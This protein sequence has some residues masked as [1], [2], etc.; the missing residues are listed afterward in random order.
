MN[1]TRIALFLD[2]AAAELARG[3]LARV[4]VQAE[5]H[6]GPLVA[7]LWFVSKRERGLRLE[8]P[9]SESE[10]AAFLLHQWEN[11]TGVLQ[12]AIRCPGCGS[13]RVDF[14]QFTEKSIFTNVAMGLAAEAGL[15]ERYFYCEDCHN[16]WPKPPLKRGRPRAHMAPNY[17][18]E[19]IQ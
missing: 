15:I 9:V 19:D 5:L 8:V 11:G 7:R 14:P 1:W 17:F 3:R 6:P 4:G 2:V 18:L 10:T 12:A 16:T 13:L